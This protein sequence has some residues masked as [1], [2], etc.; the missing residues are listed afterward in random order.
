MQS[1]NLKIDSSPA[2]HSVCFS[3]W[4]ERSEEWERQSGL[5]DPHTH[6]QA[7]MSAAESRHRRRNPP[8]AAVPC[9]QPIR[10]QP[11]DLIGLRPDIVTRRPDNVR[12]WSLDSVACRSRSSLAVVLSL[13]VVPTR[14]R[15]LLFPLLPSLCRQH[16]V[17]FTSV[18]F[19]LL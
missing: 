6:T 11:S 3:G 1:K 16:F 4:P 5:Y 7:L 18:T 17:I 19:R 8:S 14:Q 12:F 15:I 13:K 9:L 10:C 2:Q